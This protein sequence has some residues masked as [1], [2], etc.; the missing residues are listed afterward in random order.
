MQAPWAGY[1]KQTSSAFLTDIEIEQAKLPAQFQCI[2]LLTE[3]FYRKLKYIKKRTVLSVR[4]LYLYFLQSLTPQF[5][6]AHF[7]LLFHSFPSFSFT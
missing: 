1:P 2:L 5:T 6:K 3:L 7:R 4:K